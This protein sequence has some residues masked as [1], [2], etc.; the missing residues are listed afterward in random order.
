VRGGFACATALLL[1]IAHDAHAR[2]WAAYTSDNFT[3][4]SDAR[5]EDVLALINDF[6]EFRHVALRILN[7]PDEPENERLKIVHPARMSDFQALAGDARIG[8]FFYHREFGPRMIVAPSRAGANRTSPYTLYHEYVHYL[9]DQRS[10]LN[11]PPWYKE[12]L[13]TVLMRVRRSETTI[14]V[15][16]P[17]PDL[18]KTRIKA[19][20]E[21]IINT[22]YA[23]GIHDFYTMSWLFTHY[24]AID[25]YDKPQRKRRL[26]DYLRRYDAGEDPVEAFVESF[27]VAPSAMQEE[28]DAYR[29]QSAMNVFRYPRF[30]YAGEIVRRTLEDG[31]DLYLLGGLATELYRNRAALDR[32][33]RFDKSHPD[34]P[35][36]LKVR[37]RRAVALVHDE[38]LDEADAVVDQLIAMHSEDPD[39]M[40]D[41]AHYFHDR[42]EIE[43]DQPNVDGRANLERS[44]YYGEKALAGNPRDL[45]THFYLGRAYEFSGE[46]E[47]AIDILAR[48][49]DMT[50]SVANINQTFAR[51]LYK[52]GHT[53]DAIFVLNRIYSASHLEAR[54]ERYGELIEQMRAGDVDPE[55]LDPYATAE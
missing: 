39:V 46:L 40:A 24:L 41:I 45:A 3:L 21:D 17:L 42:F 54:R 10:E 38:R 53:D 6:E 52:G 27:G 51:V 8:G 44:I 47:R 22:D 43:S 36:R 25:S 14:S 55:W 19:T 13:A 33:D 23:G 49:F 11:Y 48:A 2:E 29:R 20:V 34:S 12:G 15:G 32:F 35:L 31:E 9:M 4:Y 50:P 18:A 1:L 16:V 5:E 28:M 26:S 30:E 7:L 37:S